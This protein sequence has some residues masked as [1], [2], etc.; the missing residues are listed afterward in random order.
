MADS[1]S[2]VLIVDDNEFRRGR[3]GQQLRD[4]G[5]K[6]S[7]VRLGQGGRR[8]VGAG[9][10]LRPAVV[11]FNIT[12]MDLNAIAAIAIIRFLSPNTGIVVMCSND[13]A[14]QLSVS[15]DIGV[16]CFVRRSIPPSHLRQIICSLAGWDSTDVEA[17]T[18]RG[19][20]GSS[21]HGHRPAKDAEGLLAWRKAATWG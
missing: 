12:G 5:V 16:T 11:V 10:M 21:D 3:L 8:A 20:A 18:G 2:R 19:A 13:D 6:A 4:A 1:S 15:G 7:A 17:I 9:V 14:M